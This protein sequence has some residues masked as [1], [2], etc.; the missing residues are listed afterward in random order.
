[1]PIELQGKEYRLVAE[2]LI[3]FFEDFQPKGF[4]INTEVYMIGDDAVVI[5][6]LIKDSDGKIVSTGHARRELDGSKALEKCETNAVGRALAFLGK[7]LMGSEIASADEVSDALLQQ[8]QKQMWDANRAFMDAYELHRD[9]IVAI[10]DFLAEDNFDAAKEAMNE[11][12]NEDKNALNRAWTK[13]GPFNPRETK[14]IKWWSNDF[15]ISAKTGER[16]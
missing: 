13:G 7:D 16:L 12:P 9:S 14:Q 8:Q 5:E 6:A 11:I 10:K 1:M 3:T 15:E 2:R 4:I